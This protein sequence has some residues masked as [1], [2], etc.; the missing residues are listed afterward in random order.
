MR[1]LAFILAGGLTSLVLAASAA[2]HE[3]HGSCTVFGQGT[4][5][6]AQ[7]GPPGS[8]GAFVSDSAPANDDIAFLHAIECE[9]RP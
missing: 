5:A 8:F 3:S 4:A 1:K 9:A 7:S 6:F 2:A